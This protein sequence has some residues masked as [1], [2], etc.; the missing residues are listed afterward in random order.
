MYAEGTFLDTVRMCQM[1]GVMGDRIHAM[2]SHYLSHCF[3]K[4]TNKG[5]GTNTQGMFAD[6]TKVL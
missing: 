5:Q 6:S 2:Y 1:F 4:K 3:T